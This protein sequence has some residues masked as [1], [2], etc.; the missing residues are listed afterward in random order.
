MLTPCFLTDAGSDGELELTESQVKEL[1]VTYASS[2]Y[3]DQS[4]LHKLASSL[5]L[6]KPQVQVRMCEE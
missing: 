3:P 1:E 5:E 4:T 2:Q 6:T